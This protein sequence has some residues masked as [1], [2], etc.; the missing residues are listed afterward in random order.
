M[1]TGYSII[2][3][4]L[5]VS[6]SAAFM[7]RHEV[8]T[9]GTDGIEAYKL[10]RITGDVIAINGSTWRYTKRLVQDPNAAEAPAAEA[11][12]PEAAPPDYGQ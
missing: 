5:I 7:F 6:L 9:T 4:A 3:A 11:P 2:V 1:N 10:D 12:A 8:V